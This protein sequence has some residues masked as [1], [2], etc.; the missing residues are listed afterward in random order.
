MAV[1]VE[2]CK[3]LC[4]LL[5]NSKTAQLVITEFPF[6]APLMKRIEAYDKTVAYDTKLFDLR[7]L[8]LV[9]ALNPSSRASIT[10]KHSGVE[11][12]VNKMID[13]SEIIEVK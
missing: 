1:T 8:F 4:N 7:L 5:F 2:S 10:Q 9:T 12:L 11:I 6:M 3:L 13:M